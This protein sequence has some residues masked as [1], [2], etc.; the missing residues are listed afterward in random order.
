MISAVRTG[1]AV[2]IVTA[3]PRATASKK[4]KE[5]WVELLDVSRHYAIEH[6]NSVYRLIVHSDSLH[7]RWIM[8]DKKRIYTLGGSAKDAGDR[9]YFTIKPLESSAKNL[10]QIQA[11]IDGG[12]EYFGP[13]TAIHI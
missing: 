1:V 6:G 9:Q 5:R 4:D 12:K 13:S 11:H 7:D 3:E 8:F 2:T 10:A